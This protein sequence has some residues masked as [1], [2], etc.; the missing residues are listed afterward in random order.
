[1]KIIKEILNGLLK[2]Y[3]SNQMTN[4]K[5]LSIYKSNGKI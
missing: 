2:S 4:Q 5:E 3:L 1:M